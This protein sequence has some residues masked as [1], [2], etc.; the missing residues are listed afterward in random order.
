MTSLK[1]PLGDVNFGKIQRRRNDSMKISEKINFGRSCDIS[2]L[3]VFPREKSR[4]DGNVKVVEGIWSDRYKK[5][6]HPVR[7][8]IKHYKTRTYTRL[9]ALISY[10]S[11]TTAVSTHSHTQLSP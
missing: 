10:T 11:M 7:I 1:R 6:F 5:G 4:D 9:R 2:F 8:L 3:I